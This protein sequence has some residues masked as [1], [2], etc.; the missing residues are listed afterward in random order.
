MKLKGF[1]QR[2]RERESVLVGSRHIGHMRQH[3]TQT[4]K[5]HAK[6]AAQHNVSLSSQICPL[7]LFSYFFCIF[8][9][10][11]M[12]LSHNDF[13]NMYTTLSFYEI[14]VSSFRCYK[15][16]SLQRSMFRKLVLYVA[17]F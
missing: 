5:P 8:S 17:V 9:S 13:V 6:R 3:M 10:L 1:T 11:S 2:E 4:L 7:S 12:F 15:E 16:S 14:L